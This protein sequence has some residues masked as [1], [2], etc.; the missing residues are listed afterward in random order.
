MS[1]RIYINE[2]V[3]IRNENEA[4]RKFTRVIKPYIEQINAMAEL[5][6]LN[7]FRLYLEADGESVSIKDIEC[8][9]PDNCFIVTDEIAAQQQIT[10]C[11]LPK[12]HRLFRML[13]KLTESQKIRLNIEYEILD[14]R[15]INEYG[16]NFFDLHLRNQQETLSAF[17]SYKCC[18]HYPENDP[19][20]TTH[21]YCFDETVSGYLPYTERKI[22]EQNN[23]NWM[24]EN[25]TFCAQVKDETKKPE[26]ATIL[27]YELSEYGMGH[28]EQ[29]D[30]DI[31]SVN[32]NGWI[33]NGKVSDFIGN[34]KYLLSY[35]SDYDS[36][37]DLACTVFSTDHEELI[38]V[39]VFAKEGEI[40]AE[41]CYC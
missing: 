3:E 30:D 21:L 24:I 9:E 23:R 20:D 33:E 25:F 32:R 10:H 17:V 8:S 40:R 13:D 31:V 28:V 39:K 36:E 11:V 14:S 35:I 4:T 1:I 38:A 26:L 41:Y 34:L 16:A 6:D 19:L 18:M 37:P 15:Y 12:D 7:I 29:E 5:Q 22:Y 2:T 27:Q